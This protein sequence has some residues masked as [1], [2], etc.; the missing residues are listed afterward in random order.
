MNVRCQLTNN[1]FGRLVDASGGVAETAAAMRIDRVAFAFVFTLAAL[2]SISAGGAA[3]RLSEETPITIAHRGYAAVAPENTLSG[4]EAALR[5]GA[6]YVEVDVQMTADGEIVLMHDRTV[7]RTTDGTGKVSALDWEYVASLDAGSW[8]SGEHTGEQ[9]PRI[10]QALESVMEA[11]ATLAIEVKHPSR[12]SDLAEALVEAIRYRKA[13]QNVIVL[14]FDRR[15]LR[16]LRDLDP[17]I[18]TGDLWVRPRVLLPKSES[19]VASVHW[20]SLIVDPTAVWRLHRRGFRVWAWTVNSP[21]IARLLVRMGVDGITTDE[22]E[23]MQNL[24]YR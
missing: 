12:Q 17:G 3:A 18:T 11:D 4:I 24:E 2:T 15:W 20:L 1:R 6:D 22:F 7:D 23:L 19:A 14:S 16:R 10:S 9:V 8:F 13:E 5:A 21:G